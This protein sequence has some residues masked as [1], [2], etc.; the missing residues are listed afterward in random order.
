MKYC[1][2]AGHRRGDA[3]LSP[4]GL[5]SMGYHRVSCVVQRQL[6]D[7]GKK[8]RPW[9]FCDIDKIVTNRMNYLQVCS[10]LKGSPH[11]EGAPTA[12]PGPRR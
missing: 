2:G 8:A 1:R 10:P 7:G 4:E 11:I 5:G 3:K 6:P 9:R 12:D